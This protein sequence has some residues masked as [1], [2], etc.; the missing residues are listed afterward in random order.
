MSKVLILSKTFL[1][2]LLRERLL[3]GA[4]I[5]AVVLSVM[6][7]ILGSLSFA[8]KSRII[9]HLSVSASHLVTL[10][11]VIFFGASSLHKE[12]E[13][14]TCLLVLARPVSRTQFYIGKF[15][16]I[17]GLVFLVN[18]ILGS[19]IYLIIPE[20]VSIQNLLSV[21]LGVFLETLIVLAA[22]LFFSVFLSVPVALFAG[23]GTF[24]L[25]HWLPELE[26]FAQKSENPTFKMVSD[27]VHWICPHLYK[28]N[29]RSFE[30]LTEGIIPSTVLWGF[31]H[32]VS[33]ILFLIVV[34]SKLWKGKD[35]V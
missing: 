30:Y 25:G 17:S 18:I 33:W 9:F 15:L 7:A 21:Y 26:F 29:W 13:K 35:L 34:G 3:F 27:I 22:S 1:L 23:V 32:A 12:I 10:G 2:E 5:V 11:L 16:A 6:S 24:M 4:L 14:Q 20:E 28:L 31:A 8:E 19:L